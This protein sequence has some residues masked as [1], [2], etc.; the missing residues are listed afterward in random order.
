MTD[1][2]IKT[3]TVNSVIHCGEGAFE[4]YA[5][6]LKGKQ[7][8]IVTDKNVFSYYRELIWKTFGNSV[9][10]KILPAGE[11][12]KTQRYLFEILRE[13]AAAGIRRSGYV[14][15]FGGGVVGDIAGLASSLYMRGVHLVQIPTTLLSQVDSSVGGK[16]A[17]DFENVKNLIGTFYQPEE[18]IVDLRFLDTLPD[19]E[20]RCGLGEII[21]YGALDSKIYSKLANNIENLTS[22]QFL[23][24]ITA[25]CINHKAEVVKKDE[26][27]LTGV[28]KTLNLGHTTGHAF[29]LYYRRKSHGEFVLIGM[30]YE[31]Y[32]ARAQGLGSDNYFDT[33]ERLIKKVIKKLPAYDDI[34]KAALMAKFD[35]KNEGDK[36][37]S[38]VVPNK[39]GMSAEIILG[40]DEYVKLITECRD[41]LKEQNENS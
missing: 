23:G 2:T 27:D 6:E 14:I 40:I 11:T 7:L 35:K 39:Q 31:M 30:I 24:D 10:V 4:K 13:M 8:F 15:A 26:H 20:I 9:P 21:K 37:V 5:P 18:V 41:K 28:R 33:L 12:S 17:V 16:T 32:I 38:L 3:N 29:E 36:K 25:D 22:K 1:I 19:R 34:E